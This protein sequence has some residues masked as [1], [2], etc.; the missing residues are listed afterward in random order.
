MPL[1][2]DKFCVRK[3]CSSPRSLAAHPS[4]K[5][6][7]VKKQ[8]RGVRA[9][10]ERPGR[11]PAPQRDISELALPQRPVAG[12]CHVAGCPQQGPLLTCL[13]AEVGL[14]GAGLAAAEG[15]QAPTQ[16]LQLLL[17]AWVLRVK[18][19][20]LLHHLAEVLQELC[21]PA[22]SR[23]LC[24]TRYGAHAACRDES[25]RCTMQLH[26][27]PM[28][29]PGMQ[30][31]EPVILG[32][33]RAVTWNKWAKVPPAPWGQGT[34]HPNASEDVH[35]CNF[36][37]RMQSDVTNVRTG[38]PCTGVHSSMHVHVCA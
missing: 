28:H 18:Q 29:V 23:V 7:P 8:S 13:A 22:G 17:Q 10:C 1:G 27:K 38:E 33:T 31:I 32:V 3:R 24:S 34:L 30:G 35:C 4:V 21:H 2:R 36:W 19:V 16:G 37:C 11:G 14:H 20:A 5:L 15:L 26:I 25:L 9:A 6:D 12:H